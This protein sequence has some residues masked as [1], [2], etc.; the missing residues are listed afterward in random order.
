MKKA[1]LFDISVILLLANYSR[2][3]YILGYFYISK[4]DF[5]LLMCFQNKA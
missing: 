1:K 4:D 3:F 5:I 2:N